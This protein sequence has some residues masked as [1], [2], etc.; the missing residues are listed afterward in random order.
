VLQAACDL[1]AVRGFHGTSMKDIAL[2]A[3]VRAP[4]LYNHVSSKQEILFT[5]M[6]TAMDRALGALDTALRDVSDVSE[7]LQQATESLVLDFL[8]FPHE[9]TVCNAEI[10]SLDESTRPMIIAKRDQYGKQV[11]AIIEH[12]CDTGR[13]TTSS[14]RLAAY[15][16]L[17]MG[18]SAKAWFRPGGPLADTDVAERYGEFALRI[19]GDTTLQ[20]RADRPPAR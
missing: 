1:F 9:V 17:E 10:H 4:S 14:P 8:R 12:G 13:F 18:N 3:G 11:R 5:I 6:D 7:Q 20:R 15:A 2:A 16:V 19:V